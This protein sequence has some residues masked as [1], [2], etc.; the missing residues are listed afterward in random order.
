MTAAPNII[1]CDDCGQ[2]NRVPVTPVPT[3]K[4][5]ICGRCKAP[6]TVDD[7]DDAEGFGWEGDQE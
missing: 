1:E 5:V 6:L 4:R 3:G 2:L 7:D